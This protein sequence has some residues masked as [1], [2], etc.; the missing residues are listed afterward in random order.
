MSSLQ[1]PP[2]VHPAIPALNLSSVKR[3]QSDENQPPL[4]TRGATPLRSH[5]T[6]SQPLAAALSAAAARGLDSALLTSWGAP[7]PV[8][9][10]PPAAK[11]LDAAARASGAASGRKVL[12]SESGSSFS[13]INGT[14]DLTSTGVAM[15]KF[16]ESSGMNTPQL[17]VADMDALAQLIGHATHRSRTGTSHSS[18]KQR[19]GHMTERASAKGSSLLPQFT[20]GFSLYMKRWNP[21]YYFGP[22]PDAPAS[23]TSATP[24]AEQQPASPK[25]KPA[26][27]PA[28]PQSLWSAAAEAAKA[29]I[30]QIEADHARRRTLMEPKLIQVCAMM[31]CDA[32]AARQNR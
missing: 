22:P 18:K 2:A 6:P 31:M 25:V 12:L 20:K 28:A 1:R 16:L 10:V 15:S 5:D 23:P 7:V 4:V 17:P 19:R 30:A 9:P 3:G 14:L 29:K 8:K 21:S 13:S 32:A 27:A 24:S 11:S 26:V